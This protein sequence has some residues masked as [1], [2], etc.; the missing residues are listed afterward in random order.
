VFEICVLGHLRAVKDPFRAALAA[1][2]LPSSSSVRVLQ[3]GRAL[4]DAMRR[5][6]E[7]EAAV[8]PRYQWL[9]EIPRAQALR[10]LARCRLLVLTSKL[11]GGAN[12][13]SEALAADVPVVSS[14]I[15][16]S[17][18]ILGADYP[19]YFEAGDTIELAKVLHRAETDSAFYALL[20]A[21]CRR[22]APLVDPQRERQAWSELLRELQSEMSHG[23]ERTTI[24][25]RSARRRGGTGA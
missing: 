17:V 19:G 8:N 13:V 2:R 3:V 20:Q 1:R 7:R 16:G 12:V 22:V 10:R 24:S 9:G 14:R 6:A 25:A 5:R 11:E 15:G 23:E 4:T 18:G 21:A